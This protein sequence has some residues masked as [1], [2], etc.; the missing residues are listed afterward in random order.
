MPRFLEKLEK[1][2]LMALFSNDLLHPT[3]SHTEQQQRPPSSS[4]QSSTSSLS[5]SSSSSSPPSPSPSS[6]LSSS[7]SGSDGT[8]VGE[9]SSPEAED[10]APANPRRKLRR[11]T[12]FRN[13]DDAFDSSR[14]NDN[15]REEVG[16]PFDLGM[17]T[18]PVQTFEVWMGRR[19]KAGRRVRARYSGAG[20]AT[21]A[22]EPTDSPDAVGTAGVQ[23]PRKHLSP[24]VFPRRLHA[25]CLRLRPEIGRATPTPARSLEAAR[26]S[27]GSFVVE[28]ED[29]G[30]E[31]S[32]PRE[33]HA[34]KHGRRQRRRR[35]RCLLWICDAG[36]PESQPMDLPPRP[37][38]VPR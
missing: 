20:L 28:G 30:D 3:S 11:T 15:G 25:S 14:D 37:S 29:G 6:I 31:P 8:L 12:S 22:E 1:Y 10:P 16:Q 19:S 34:G 17:W 18:E 7:S 36:P 9:P 4:S 27:G 33:I 5:V 23:S 21:I 26:L 38:N 2:F 35:R 13:L 24:R 32:S